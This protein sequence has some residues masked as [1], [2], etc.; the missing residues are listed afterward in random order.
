MTEGGVSTATD[1]DDDDIE[2]LFFPDM[3][4]LIAGTAMGALI[5]R[6]GPDTGLG[7]GGALV[8]LR[9]IPFLRKGTGATRGGLGEGMG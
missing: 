9:G 8:L 5:I 3:S 1:S 6:R 4:E 7:D 2:P